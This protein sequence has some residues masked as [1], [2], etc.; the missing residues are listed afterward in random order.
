[1][2]YYTLGMPSFFKSLFF[3]R[4]RGEGDVFILVRKK[5]FL[6]YFLRRGGDYE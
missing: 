4:G 3:E 1:M 5:S 6:F 2:R